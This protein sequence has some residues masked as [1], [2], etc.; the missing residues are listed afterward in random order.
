MKKREGEKKMRTL[1]KGKDALIRFWSAFDTYLTAALKFIVSLV[2]LIFIAGA[3]GGPEI[4]GQILVIII[5]AAFASI[6]PRNSLILMGMVYLEAGFLS[7]SA[8]SAVVGGVLLLILLFLYLCFIP[9][10]TYVVVLTALC[11]GFKIPFVMPIVCGLLMGPAAAAGISFGT[12]IYYS[13]KILTGR[14]AVSAGFGSETL[15]H[16]LGLFQDTILNQELLISI[17]ILLAVF[18]VVCLIRRMPVNYSW[19]ISVVSGIFVYVLFSGMK[20]ILPGMEIAWVQLLT[21]LLVGA[22]AGFLVQFFCFALDYEKVQ[23]LQ[24]ED[25]EYY[26][27]VKAVPKLGSRNRDDEIDGNWETDGLDEEGDDRE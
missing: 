16:V 12:V 17:V 5:L 26:Y 2:T 18:F 19:Q 6:L 3:L 7:H 4:L 20:M 21:D 22:V 9:G 27:Y 1:V 23:H 25:D 10:Q 15:A 8:E 14:E 11:L 24:F 13:A